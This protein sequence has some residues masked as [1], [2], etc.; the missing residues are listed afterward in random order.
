MAGINTLQEVYKKRGLEWTRDFL[1]SELRITEK[2][3]AYR[4]SFELSKN[5]KFR[6]FG[7]N[8]EVPLN[9]IDRTVSDLY[10]TAIS[11]IE[12]LPAAIIE[13]LPR[14]HRFGFNLIDEIDLTLTDIT[15]RNHGKV[16]K[17]IHEKPVLER[18]ASLLHVKWGDPIYKGKLESSKIESILESL[19][20]GVS[21]IFELGASQKTYIIRSGEHIAKIA[22]PQ[23]RISRE[24]KSHGFDLLLLQMYESLEKIDFEAIG[25]K[26][27]RPDERYLEVVS[28]AF[29]LFVNE[30]G[31][32]FLQMGI[33]KPGFLEKSGKFNAKWIRN[34]K[35][36]EHIKENKDYEYLLS[37]FIANLRKPKKAAG[38]LTESFI[39]RYNKT[40]YDID[41]SVRNADDYEFLEFSSILVKE[42]S[43]KKEPEFSDSDSLKAVS[44]LQSF[45]ALPYKDSEKDA[46]DITHSCNLLIINVGNFTN[47]VLSECERILKLTGKSFVLIHDIN[48]GDDCNWGLNKIDGGN[49]AKQLVMDFP[50]IFE[51]TE[52]I[53]DLSL[54]QLI[55][56]ASPRII[57]RIYT[58]RS[59]DSLVKECDTL[60]TI[61]GEKLN[62]EFAKLAGN[63]DIEVSDCMDTDDYKTF[64]EIYPD[65]LQK[66]WHSMRS[67]WNSK[68]YI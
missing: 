62:I 40:I 19:Q 22:P 16:T 27:P 13:N 1:L 39:D 9:R 58:G 28:E 34:A 42:D 14:S 2:A 32:E 51:C 64:K 15:I 5:K 7:K 68:A 61:S 55:K 35:T 3:D 63:S 25:F 37:I 8:G 57:Q 24:Q 21:P 47:K 45:F 10:E 59:C 31:S 54:K 46:E 65:S 41:E 38:L 66:F 53:R 43:A 4:F 49:A 33:K 50:H 36:L 20:T 17:Q 6:F 60:D 56:A 29:N 18:W 30:R 52:S 23:L 44:M 12:K 11:K 26:S 48:A 67:E